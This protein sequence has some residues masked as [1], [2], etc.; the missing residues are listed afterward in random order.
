MYYFLSGLG[1][2]GLKVKL[3]VFRE[4]N[5]CILGSSHGGTTSDETANNY[6]YSGEAYD[7]QNITSLLG[8]SGGEVMFFITCNCFFFGHLMRSTAKYK[9]KLIVRERMK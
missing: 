8:G 4:D 1:P 6:M 2:G 7:T 5:T 3:T 9:M